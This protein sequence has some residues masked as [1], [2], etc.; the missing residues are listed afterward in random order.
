MYAKPTREDLPYLVSVD[1]LII[2]TVHHLVAVVLFQHLGVIAYA[3]NV[4]V[5]PLVVKAV[6]LQS[7]AAVNAI[8]GSFATFWAVCLLQFLNLLLTSF[9]LRSSVELV[10]SKIATWASSAVTLSLVIACYV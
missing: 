4:Q 3:L 7:I 5:L 9:S 2:W 8:V 6:F 10:A 1:I